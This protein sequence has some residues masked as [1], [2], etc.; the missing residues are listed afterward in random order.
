MGNRDEFTG[1]IIGNS[2][3]PIKVTEFINVSCPDC[4]RWFE[5]TQS[6]YAPLIATGKIVVQV[7]PYQKDK[8]ALLK[9]NEA[10]QY[11]DLSNS[12]TFLKQVTSLYNDFDEWRSLDGASLQQFFEEN[13]GPKQANEATFKE[14]EKLL[15]HYGI[16]NVPT[17]VINDHV[18][19][20]FATIEDLSTAMG[21]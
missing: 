14:A 15:K 19:D 3:A 12:D 6:F 16:E 17:I 1:V 11:L 5:K 10:H 13:L 7:Y 20:E 21:L 18:F 8:Q 2:E 9:G 4:K